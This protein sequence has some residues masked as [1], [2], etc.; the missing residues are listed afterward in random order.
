MN[1]TPEDERNRF[2]QRLRHF[3]ERESD[4][5][6]GVERT[7][8]RRCGKYCDRRAS[9]AFLHPR[10]VAQ[11]HLYRGRDRDVAKMTG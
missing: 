9:S 2:E 4:E 6:L 1:I 7:I 3:G 11:P 8:F 10:H 5:G